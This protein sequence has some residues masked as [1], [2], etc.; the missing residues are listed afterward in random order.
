MATQYSLTCINNSQQL[1][2]FAVF[3]KLPQS[4][5]NVFTLAWLARPAHPNTRVTFSWTTD[6]CFVWSETG[7]VQPGI[8]FSASRQ[9]GI[10]LAS[11][12]FAGRP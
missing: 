10:A 4:P 7:V 12:S 2:S 6:Y 1:G 3:Q 8:S 5:P 9:P 11:L